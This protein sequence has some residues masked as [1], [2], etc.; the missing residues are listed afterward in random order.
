[1]T[2]LRLLAGLA[3]D[4]A[5]VEAVMAKVL[6]SDEP[7]VNSLIDSL[8]GFHGKM[9]RPS[10]VLLVAQAMGGIR[11]EHHRLGAALEMIHT[12]T[13]IH[14]DMIDEADTRRGKPTAH[15]AHGTSIAVLL[16][17]YFYTH[18]FSLVSDLTH[19]W[20]MDRLTRTTNVVCRGELHQMIARR[21]VDLTEAEY[22]R[23]IYAK[24]AALT[25]LAG[26]LGAVSGTSEQRA[27]AAAYGRCIGMAFQ[28]VD[29]CLDFTGDPQ[30]VGKTLA[31]D[32]ERG[33]LTLP[34]LR[35]LAATEPAR[36][37]AVAHELVGATSPS[38][39][40][41]VRRRVVEGGGVASAL[42]TARQHVA[43]AK[44]HLAALPAGA[45]RDRLGELADFIVARDF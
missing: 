12:A 16:G 18:A 26:E 29:D 8:G 3:S 6:A 17:D 33:R 30:K 37:H 45:G 28:I 13:L 44:R 31:T 22:D 25:E 42:G 21:D 41:E 32:I 20:V 14:D 23:I 10:V 5:Q 19:P 38:A 27:G 35:L 7:R 43:E 4:L 24:T 2:V 36:R 11:P 40:A 15:V 34:I 1:V 9:L 39:V